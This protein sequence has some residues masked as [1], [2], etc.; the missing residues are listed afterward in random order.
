MATANPSS[1]AA[2]L[3]GFFEAA[4]RSLTEAQGTLT[5]GAM[6]TPSALAIADAELE[7]KAAVSQD[8]TGQLSLQTLSVQNL[9]SGTIAPGLVSTVKI[10]YVAV[11][12]ESVGPA[13]PKRAPADVVKEVRTRADLQR[14]QKVL[15]DLSIEPVFV[16]E[17]QR[18]LVTARDSAGRTVRE[19]V[20]SDEP[21]GGQD[22]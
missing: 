2:P 9:Q 13:P 14:L 6:P 15:G 16:P 4:G 1:G 17:R 11:P 5:A 7:I 22:A 20:L 19:V 8:A 12:G 21:T 3:R 18:W 10:H